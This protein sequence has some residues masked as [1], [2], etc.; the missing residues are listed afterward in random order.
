MANNYTR[1]IKETQ[2]PRIAKLY[3]SMS[4]RAIA[5]KYGVTAPAILKILRK[6]KV[7]IRQQH[8]RAPNAL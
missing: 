8:Q 7:T 6:L 1:K 4:A 3:A 2:H 5:D